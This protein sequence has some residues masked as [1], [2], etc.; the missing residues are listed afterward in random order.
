MSESSIEQPRQP[1][2][3]L[4]IV[5]DQPD[6]RRGLIMRLMLEQDLMVVGEA[7]DGDKALLLARELRPAVILMDVGMAGMDGIT[8]TSALRDIIPESRVVILSLHDDEATC[9]RARAAG[10]VFVSKQ[11][12]DATLLAAIRGD[13]SG[14]PAE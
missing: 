14:Q 3:S 13:I 1:V 10:A 4:L 9:V 5:D 11:A 8:A 7:G 12:P 6:V 2:I